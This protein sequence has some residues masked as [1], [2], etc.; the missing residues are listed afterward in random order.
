MCI[1]SRPGPRRSRA[2]AFG[3][4]RECRSRVRCDQFGPLARIGDG[5]VHL[6]MANRL[7]LSVAVHERVLRCWAAPAR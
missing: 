7:I 5:Q 2:A 3:R 4:G 1:P 6:T